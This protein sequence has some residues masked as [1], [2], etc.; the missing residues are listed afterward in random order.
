MSK[1]NDALE[2]MREMHVRKQADYARDGEFDN[3]EL[4]SQITGL[5]VEETF[6]AQIG[7]KMARIKTLRAKDGKPNNESLQDSRYDLAVYAAMYFAYHLENKSDT[8][9]PNK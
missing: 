6:L 8:K 5:T 7:N 2:L 3:F 9:T 1:F 4:T